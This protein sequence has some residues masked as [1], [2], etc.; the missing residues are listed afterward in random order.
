MAADIS[1]AAIATVMTGDLTFIEHL[2]HRETPVV[3]YI[4]S[5]A[6]LAGRQAPRPEEDGG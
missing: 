3:A 6:T 1:S 2:L 5:A 4:V